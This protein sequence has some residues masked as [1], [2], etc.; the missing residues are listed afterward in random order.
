GAGPADNGAKAGDVKSGKGG[1]DNNSKTSTTPTHPPEKSTASPPP[2]SSDKSASPPPQQPPV[3]T[4]ASKQQPSSTTT[5][6]SSDQSTAANMAAAEDE[7]VLPLEPEGQRQFDTILRATNALVSQDS[8][9]KAANKNVTRLAMRRMLSDHISFTSLLS[10]LENLQVLDLSGNDLGPQAI[11]TL[12][13]ALPPTCPLVSLNIADNKTDTDTAESI[14]TLLSK[15]PPLA[16]L[17]VSSNYLGKDFFAR[18]I[19]QALKSNTTLQTLRAQSIGMVDA[20]CLL[21]GLMENS[22]LVELDISNNDITDRKALGAGFGEILKKSDCLLQSL[23]LVGCNMSPEGLQLL[24]EGL[25]VN[26]SLQALNLN[27]NEFGTSQAMLEF[28]FSAFSH[29]ALTNLHLNDTRVKDTDVKDPPPPS[30]AAA[31]KLQ[32]LSMNSS[33]VSDNFFTC[34][35]TAFQGKLPCLVDVDISNNSGLTATVMEQ[36]WKITSGDGSTSS[37]RKLTTA[38]NEMETLATQLPVEKFPH[39]TYLNVRKARFSPKGLTALAG[40]LSPSGLPLS[41]LV[42]DGMKLSGKEGLK[43]LF[44]SCAASKMTAL[45]LS[46]CSLN[47]GDLMPLM[48]A[49]K[50]GF[51]LHMLKLSSNRLTD[52]TPKSL[53]ESLVSFP[54]H[55]LSVL[56]LSSNQISDGGAKDLCSIYASK[57]HNSSLHSLNLASNAIGKDG[58]LALVSVMGSKSTLKCLYVNDQTTSFLEADIEEVY[59]RLAASLGFTVKKSGETI[60]KGCSDL[61]SLPDGLSINLRGLGGH[62]GELGP[63]LDCPAIAT[64]S[65]SKRLTALTLENVFDICAVLQGQKSGKCVLSSGDWNHV[66]GADKDNTTPSWLQLADSRKNGI[67]LGNLPGNTTS[68]RL[69]ALLEME[70]DCSIEEVVLMKDPVTKNIS[71]SAWILLSDETSVQRAL[72]FY[73][74]GEA[75][76]FGT[77]FSVARLKVTVEDAGSSE[78]AAKARQDMVARQKARAAE[79][80]AHRLLIQQNTEESWKRHAYRLAHPAY[81]DGR[82]W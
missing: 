58:L 26:T 39:L 76:V 69:E 51:K 23:A 70:A 11:R 80:R 6:P 68:Q 66:T 35:A 27:N 15:G 16:Y 2:P 30:S 72:D 3:T 17:D 67:Y 8:L 81:A 12:C 22:S 61:P 34:L 9:L 18:C 73:N 49:L 29:P 46:G 47:D 37:I 79:D 10:K 40:V 48:D 74:R 56:D 4:T 41:T 55:P 14:G 65:A 63:M 62:I 25:A 42:M 33:Q 19:G 50:S 5:L 24:R 53:S 75:L 28:V 1:G 59:V 78:A 77:P 7:S 20:K 32:V 64:D 57:N 82:I 44:A 21:E 54:T 60:E 36:L 38:M 43:K 71:G 31:S 45:S 52:A 13:L